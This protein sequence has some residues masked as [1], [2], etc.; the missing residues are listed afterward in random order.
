MKNIYKKLVLASGGVVI[1]LGSLTI[2]MP[3]QAVLMRYDFSVTNIDGGIHDGTTGSGYFTFDSEGEELDIGSGEVIKQVLDFEFNWL[4][5]TFG[6]EALDFE[7]DGD[8]VL[9][10]NGVFQSLDW[11]YVADA[12]L[13]WDLFENEFDYTDLSGFPFNGSGYGEVSYEK[14]EPV[15]DV[16]EP[17]VVIGLGLVG[18]GFWLNKKKLSHR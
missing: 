13:S 11:D 8:G 12:N 3:A 4:G 5:Q 15:S 9:F 16:P 2:A 7:N 17:G 14:Q 1:S 18:L 6:V 10:E